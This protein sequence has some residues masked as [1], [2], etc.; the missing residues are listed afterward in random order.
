MGSDD[1]AK[2][3]DQKILNWNKWGQKDINLNYIQ[4]KN[5]PRH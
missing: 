1:I 5:V 3:K 2:L 4:C